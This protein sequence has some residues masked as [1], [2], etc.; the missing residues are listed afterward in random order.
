MHANVVVVTDLKE[1]S[2]LND[3]DKAVGKFQVYGFF[4][5]LNTRKEP[6]PKLGDRIRNGQS[7]CGSKGNVQL[8]SGCLGHWAGSN[9]M[10][11]FEVQ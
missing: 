11:D 4:F 7:W 8:S 2:V 5:T 3:R 9:H 1:K 10:H 6:A